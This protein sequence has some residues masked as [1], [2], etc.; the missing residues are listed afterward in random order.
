M[1]ESKSE[2]KRKAVQ[3]A[4]GQAPA[5][6]KTDDAAEPQETPDEAREPAK[7]GLDAP[8]EAAPVESEAS[9]QARANERETAGEGPE[10]P[11]LPEAHNVPLQPSKSAIYGEGQYPVTFK[12]GPGADAPQEPD[13]KDLSR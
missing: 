4:E 5:A 9:K 12:T 6:P 2:S 1:A 7:T 11:G 13:P 10:Q 3:R 8:S